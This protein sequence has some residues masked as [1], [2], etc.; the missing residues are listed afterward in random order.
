SLGF[1]WRWVGGTSFTRAG[2]L[3]AEH[4]GPGPKLLHI[5]HLET[6]FEPSSPVQRF[7]RLDDSTARG[8]GVIDMKG[9][10]VI[11]VAA[12]RA[13][14]QAGV[15]PKMNVTIVYHGDEEDAGA[16]LTEAR[17][18]VLEAAHGASAAI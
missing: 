9:G 18:T 14:K 1:R 3:V 7:E 16:P 4:P 10:D 5:G 17:R 11:I 15:L 6:A 2:H 13:L 12:L 8:T